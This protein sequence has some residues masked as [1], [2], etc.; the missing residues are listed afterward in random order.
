M[1]KQAALQLINGLLTS[2]RT[3][4]V[5]CGL[6][7]PMRIESLVRAG[8][9][10]TSQRFLS[11]RTFFRLHMNLFLG[12]QPLNMTAQAAYLE[13]TAQGYRLGVQSSALSIESLH[14]WN[15]FLDSIPFAEQAV[16]FSAPEPLQGVDPRV[17]TVLVLGETLSDE[18]VTEL[19]ARGLRVEN[20]CNTDAAVERA[21]SGEVAMVVATLSDTD[22]SAIELC[23]RLRLTTPNV[24]TVL[25]IQRDA[26]GDFDKGL[27]LGAVSVIYQSGNLPMFI[28]RLAACCHEASLSP[29]VAP[30]LWTT[31][32]EIAPPPASIWHHPPSFQSWSLMLSQWVAVGLLALASLA[33]SGQV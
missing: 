23:Q 14:T 21:A 2:A 33:A 26:A 8:C 11:P 32:P 3:T 12:T 4:A 1:T 17:A 5:V 31:V 22:P 28:D 24:Q 30:T 6:G 10:L 16:P 20:V 18:S 9:V 29:V 13:K 27:A 19:R 7:I 15:Q 25:L